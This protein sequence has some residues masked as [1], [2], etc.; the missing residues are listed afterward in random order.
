[1]I[2]VFHHQFPHY[3]FP[4]SKGSR[5]FHDIIYKKV[6]TSFSSTRNF[7]F[8]RTFS[9]KKLPKKVSALTKPNKMNRSPLNENRI[10]RKRRHHLVLSSFRY[11]EISFH[12]LFNHGKFSR[13]KHSRDFFFCRK[14]LYFAIKFL[15]CCEKIY[16]F[17]Y[18]WIIDWKVEID[19]RNKRQPGNLWAVIH[20][21]I[22]YLLFLV[23]SA[24]SLC[25]ETFVLSIISA[26]SGVEIAL[27]WQ[28]FLFLFPFFKKGSAR[29]KR[30]YLLGEHN[31]LWKEESF[32]KWN[33]HCSCISN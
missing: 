10:G 17:I 33:L 22:F 15:H 2:K 14:I 16:S 18:G 32:I 23:Q 5:N 3:V 8:W 6:T 19:A 27:R 7:Q 28:T 24:F 4:L 9:I 12:N 31:K 26:C 29:S 25:A 1:M 30:K 13:K 11:Q 20:L 21:L